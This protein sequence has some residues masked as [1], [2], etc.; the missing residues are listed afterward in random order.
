VGIYHEATGITSTYE[1]FN[2]SISNVSRGMY[3]CPNVKTKYRMVSLNVGTPIWMRGPGEA[4][5][6]FALESALDEISYKL[7][8][9]PIKLRIINNAETDPE[10]GKPFSSKYL[11]EAYE[12]G[13]DKIGWKDRS[14][15]PRA[16]KEGEYFVGYG[17]AT[18][19]FGAYRDKATASAK[20]L[21]NGQLEIRCAAADIGPGTT[22]AMAQIAA[23]AFKFNEENIKFL[24]GDS[25][26][27]DA[28]SQGGSFTIATVGSAVYDSCIALQKKLLET[29]SI[30]DNNFRSVPFEEVVFD[31]GVMLKKSDETIKISYTDILKNNN[32]PELIV[33]QQS[34][35]AD[36]SKYSMS[37]FSVHFTKVHVHPLTGVVKIVQIVSVADSGTIINTKTARSQMIGG[38]TGGIG[39]ALTEEGEI[40]HRYGR[41]VNNNLAD[42]HLP[43]HADTPAIETYFINKKDPVINPMGAKGMGEIA[44]I[45]FAASVANAVY[46]ATGKRIRDLPITPDKLI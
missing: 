36:F 11:K 8:I 24:L 37:S 32:L 10:S 42:Y 6:A 13:A 34:V 39:M 22:T 1:S 27:P 16:K 35:P 45:G 12:I 18:G 19:R 20:L 7:N 33:T 30:S 9:D 23:D 40:D 2:E 28:P 15:T 31:D 38:A 5:G 26:F 17:M 41:H 43:V 44:L 29:A 14:A 46:N 25:S 21:A 4:T 3:A